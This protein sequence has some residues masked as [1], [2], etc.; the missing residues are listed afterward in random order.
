[1]R[2][3]SIPA[4]C[5]LASLLLLAFLAGCYE[6]LTNIATPDKLVYFDDLVGDYQGVDAETGRMSLGKGKADTT[7]AYKQYDAK[8]TLVNEGGLWII[9]LD[10]ELFYQ[11][12]VDGYAT[13]DGRAVYAIGR[14]KLE[15]ESGARTLTG[16]AFK[17]EQTLFGDGLVK[18]EEYERVENGERK[19]HRALAMEAGKLQAYLALRAGV[20]TEPT[21]RYRRAGAA[22]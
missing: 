3:A 14:L 1:M 8:G 5:L 10:D 13:S 16:Y 4:A 17:S 19:K 7:Y 11:L 18:S 20:M 21:L 6:S 12:S 15:G 9:K 2:K 22:R